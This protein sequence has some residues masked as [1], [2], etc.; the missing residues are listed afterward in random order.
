[1]LVQ[2]EAFKIMNKDLIKVVK[3]DKKDLAKPQVIVNPAKVEKNIRHKIVNVIN[4]WISERQ[5]NSR[6]EK[7]FSESNISTWKI[8]SKNFIEPMTDERR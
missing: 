2:S 1:M 5:E 8:M 4:N 3:R 6:R 7:V